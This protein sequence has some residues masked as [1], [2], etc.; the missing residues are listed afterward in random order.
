MKKV[1]KPI[2]GPAMREPRKTVKFS[3][4]QNELLVGLADM[5]D[6]SKSGEIMFLVKQRLNEL[7]VRYGTPRRPRPGK[8]RSEEDEG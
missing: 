7:G 8:K 5:E 4:E 6:R 3:K 1:L 2:E